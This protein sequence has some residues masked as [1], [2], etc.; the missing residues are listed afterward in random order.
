MLMWQNGFLT[1]DKRASRDS[2]GK[3]IIDAAESTYS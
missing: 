1:I 3:K 2:M